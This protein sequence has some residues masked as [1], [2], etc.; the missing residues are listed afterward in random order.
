MNIELLNKLAKAY[1]LKGVKLVGRVKHGVLSNNYIVQAGGA[2]YFLKHYRITVAGRVQ[3]VHQAKQIF[4]KH[5]VPVVLPLPTK[6]GTTY[7]KLGKDA[8]ALFPYI[9]SK[10][11]VNGYELN[12]QQIQNMARM[13]AHM[14][15]LSRQRLPKVTSVGITPWSLS[16]VKKL[17]Q[18]FVLDA[19]EI[20]VI[21][22]AKKKK[23]QFD[24]QAESGLLL[25]LQ[26]LSDIP[27]TFDI[28]KLGKPH[29]LHGDF[30]QRNVFF[31]PDNTVAHVFDFEKSDIQ[32]RA[33]EL[34]RSAYIMFFT[35]KFTARNFNRA[36]MYLRTY[37]QVYPISKS[38]L[39]C[40][41]KILYYRHILSLWIECE[42]YKNHDFRPD[43]FLTGNI[44]YLKY[45]H[46]HGSEE[47]VNK[48]W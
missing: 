4:Y 18:D 15:N 21:I 25:K 48:I 39:E 24:L 5:G 27:S 22:R 26:L 36:H 31:N 38:E 40:A 43:Q 10:Q 16:Y 33:F 44:L 6:S 41:V 46:K 20:L 9:N 28:R 12:T 42:H 45:F 34:I 29:F 37:R 35:E 23:T 19:N 11:V 7:V 3:D 1:E 14:H 30:H 32:P 2:K 8:Y 47:F 13:L 17:K